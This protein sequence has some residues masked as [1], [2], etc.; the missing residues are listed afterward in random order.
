MFTKLEDWESVVA[1]TG[2]VLK[3]QPHNLEA[4]VL[5]GRAYFYLNGERQK[6]Q[7]CRCAVVENC[8]VAIQQKLYTSSSNLYIVS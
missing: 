7:P 6:D 5:R 1:L 4:M 8:R 2:K 3:S